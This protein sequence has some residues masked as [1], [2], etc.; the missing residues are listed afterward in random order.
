M[1]FLLR[2]YGGD[3]ANRLFSFWLQSLAI[4]GIFLWSSQQ[5]HAQTCS[6]TIRKVT[7]SGCYLVNGQSKATVSVE[8]GWTNAPSGGVITVTTGSQSR[9][10][11]PG[12]ISVTYPQA[13]NSSP[14]TGNQTI[15]SPQVVAFEVDANGSTNNALTARFNATCTTSTTFNAPTACPTAACSGNNVGGMVFKDFNDN[16]IKEAGETAGVSDIAV[17]AI[18]CDGTVYTTTTDGYGFYS[19]PVPANKYPV[20]VEFSSVPSIYKLGVNGT[21]SRTSVQFVNAPSCNVHLGIVNPVEFCSDN[22]LKVF[23]PCF[24]YGDPLIASQQGVSAANLSA[25][26]DALVSI[27]YRVSS[28]T[29]QGEQMITNAGK[30]GTVWGLA[31]NKYTKRLFLSAVLKRHAGLG[32]LGLGG[33]YVMNYTNSASPT[34][35]NFIDVST[36]GIPVGTIASNSTRGLQADKTQPSRD[37]QAFAAIGKVGI[38]DMDISDDGNKLWL[39][40]LSDKKLYSIDITQ[41]NQN[42]TLPTNSNVQQ[43]TVPVTCVGGEYRPWAIKAYNGKVYIG[44][45][46]DAST[47]SKTNL[48]ASVYELDGT[49]FTEIFDFPLTYPKGYPAA[50]NTSITGW[51]PWT[52]TFSDLLEGTVLR[53]PVPM[54]TDIEFDV[55]GSMVLAFGDRTGLQGGDANYRPDNSSTTLYETNSQAGDILRAFYANGTFVLENNAKAGPNVGYAANNSQGPGFGEFYNDNWIQDGNPNRIWHAEQ[56]MGGLA[57]KPG[58]GE[59]V[60]T[61]IDPV[62]QQPYAGG[63][64]YMDN[65]DGKVTGAYSVYVTRTPGNFQV[66][67][68]F[69]KAT[70]LGDIELSCDNLD[71]IEI[72]NRTWL[73]TNKDGIQDACEK[74]LKDVS[75]TLYKGN[76]KI[77]TTT[78]DA[79]GEY[80]FSRK[81]KL[82]T[83][84]WSGTGADTTL[85]PNTAYRLVFGTSGQITNS[86]DT[87]KLAGLG[88]F[89]LT[90][91]D[92]TTGTGNDHNDSD[93]AKASV[94]GEGGSFPVITLTTGTVAMTNHT[95]DAGFYCVEPYNYKATVTQATCTGITANSDAKIELTDV[96]CADKYAFSKNSGGKFTGAAYASATALTGTTITLN[97]LAN[98]ATAA[99]DTFY[100]RLYNGLCCYK[101]T[102]IILPFKDCSCIKP[103]VTATPKNQVICQGGTI[104]SY[105]AVTLPSAGITYRWY[106]P[107]TDTTGTLGTAISGQTNA[108][109][110]PAGGFTGRRYYAVIA[111]GVAAICS[112]TAFVSLTINVRPMANATAKQQ[113]ICVGDLPAAFTATPSSGVSY[114]WYGALSDTT[115]SLG[116]TISG[117]TSATYTPS[118]S[119]ITTVGTK[120]YAV[121]VTNNQT[122]CADTA[123]VRLVVNKKPTA[124]ADNTGTNAICNTV[125]TINLPDAA[126]GESWTQL[127]T[128]PSVATIDAQTG[129]VTG[130][131][132]LG[133]YQFILRNPQTSCADTV[134]VE[135]KN[136]QKGSIGDYVWKDLNDNGVQDSGEPGVKGVIVQLL[137]SATNAVLAT[138]TTD[139]S[140]L[141]GFNGLESG[142]YKVKIVLSSLPDSCVISSKQNQGG[143]DSKDSD[144][145]P[146]TGESQVVVIN[147]LGTGL[148]KDN[149][150]I[151]AGL[152]TPKGSIGDYVW[153]DLNDNGVQDSGEPGVRGVIVQLLNSTTSAVLA[154]DTTDESGLYSFPNLLS[155]SYQVKIVVTSLPDSCTISS[156]QNLG[157]DDTKDSDFSPTTGLSQVVTID[158]KG[159]GIV[160]DNPTIDAGLFTP[161]GSIGDYVWKDQN[162]NGVQDSGE[163][164]VAGVIVQ[165]LQGATVL[166]TDTTDANGLYLFPNLLSGTYQ[167]KILTSS[168]PAGCVLSSKQDLGGDDTKDSDFNPTTGLSQ[169]VTINT[170]G[171]GIAKDNPTVDGALF[172]PKGSIGDYV[173][174]DLNDNGIQDSGEPGVAGVIVQLLN[175]TTSAVLATDTTNAQGLYLFSDL[176]SGSYQVKI[177]VTSLPDSCTISTKQNLGGDDTKDSDFSPTTG[178]SQVVVIDALGTGTAKD[179][180][181]IDAALV[182]PCITTSFTLT[183]APVCSADVQTYSLTF[184]VTGKNGAIKVDKGVL[185]GNNPYTVT[186][187][188]SGASVRIVDTLS[189]ICVQDTII[190]GP[191]C[192]CNPPVPIL[193]A[194]SLTVCKGDT[195]PTL[196]A[197][198]VGLAT[199]E[200]FSQQTGGTVLATGLN[201]K[202]SGVVTAN[203]VFYAQARSTD[204]TCPTAVSTSRVPATINA[205]DC[206][207]DLALKKLINKK[208]V[209]IG[210][211][212]TYTIKVWNESAN[213]ASGVS[214]TDSIASTVQFIAGSFTPSRG[215]ASIT[216]SVITWNIGNIA[217]NGDTVTLTYRIK[218]IQ[219]G[220]HYNTAQIC[221][222]NEGDVD[223]T[224]CNNNEEED[225]I[226]R[227]CFTVPIKLCPTEKIEVSVPSKYTNV[228]WFKDGGTTPVATGNSTLLSDVGTYTFTATNNTCPAEGCCPI[229]IVPGENCCPVD[230]CIPFTIKQT[231]KAGKKL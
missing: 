147:T 129:A 188:P 5:A 128:T 185:S 30:I 124:G 178:L 167:V 39:T 201:Y 13:N 18:A 77:A 132:S 119:A 27:P 89:L 106:G 80:Y 97:N 191:N 210:D 72:G 73:D 19:I 152:F 117:A 208:V 6:V 196:K 36:I 190:T 52:D 207:I 206:E 195:F 82:T 131:T 99:G 54:F 144:F 211:T 46:C 44:G 205:Q 173:W 94:T 20:R 209:Q 213:N 169:L 122:S 2:I 93:A 226:D 115:G 107:L 15:V 95:F 43:F 90:V 228:Q 133:V 63:V 104:A 10:I 134:A 176:S 172:S 76:T 156:K 17:K 225:D 149:P 154:T 62:D 170:F 114:R 123:F 70:G 14:L 138:D 61:T 230:L 34:V 203:T 187:I 223:S 212:L 60:V 47:S 78:T 160:K 214:V 118:G 12:T 103:V 31:Y 68:T 142:S 26:A 130:L 102:T 109:F 4:I 199:V 64:R 75:V 192:N 146:T 215:T 218:A 229:I 53:H 45:V 33:L 35:S 217:A 110:T 139:V 220:I 37:T 116:T 3:Y 216:G 101:D 137:N 96:K 51:F 58:S 84:T 125:G 153:K 69:A 112:D 166:A 158:A 180:M 151:D 135:V 177:V 162:D 7:V 81:S 189:A 48:R 11:T 224:P 16:G 157:G 155:G 50:I 181:T 92:A 221:A 184:S 136:C 21:N 1:K 86:N 171:T 145:S 24:T 175:A 227:Q 219:E 38:G 204:P 65:S 127:G 174:K 22:N 67:G 87:L 28:S 148:Q 179:N 200:W 83:G 100:V 202:P 25:N 150:T 222:A 23:V 121:I 126:A 197:T 42:G 111:T 143:D 74:G 55:D 8:V 41:Y 161:K 165:L 71:I 79:N 182:V 140:G 198:V 59:V 29:F 183:G 66:P 113:T 194:P 32:P 49:T 98:P 88:K 141:Y 85:L 186:G 120:Y 105:T 9:T 56:I 91:K 40:N 57:L 108:S 231:K 168:L 159:T 163:P 193:L 164:P